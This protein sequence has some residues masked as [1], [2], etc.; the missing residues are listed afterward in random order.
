METLTQKKIS[1]SIDQG[2]FLADYKK[3][4][5]SNQSSIVRKALDSLIRDI[6]RERRR[7]LMKMKA[8]ELLSDYK[9]DKELSKFTV[10][11]GE[12]IL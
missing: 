4:G 9:E 3:W 10:L 12:D 11:D 2:R 5:F 8:G 7:E 6:K 1:I